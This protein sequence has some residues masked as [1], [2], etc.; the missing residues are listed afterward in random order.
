M[1][2][3]DTARSLLGVPVAPAPCRGGELIAAHT[4]HLIP[5]DSGENCIVTPELVLFVQSPSVRGTVLG[6]IRLFVVCYNNPL[7]LWEIL[8]VCLSSL[9]GL[10]HC[11]FVIIINVEVL[12]EIWPRSQTV[13]HGLIF[14]PNKQSSSY[15]RSCPK[16][17]LQFRKQD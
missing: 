13:Q 14:S 11:A 4:S 16:M 15:A 1:L 17:P 9:T 10:F 8:Y 12:P 7:A 2:Q 6:R 3:G 5:R